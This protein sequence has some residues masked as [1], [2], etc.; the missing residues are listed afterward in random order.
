MQI[1]E[2]CNF[3]GLYLRGK[4]GLSEMVGCLSRRQVSVKYRHYRSIP[5]PLKRSIIEDAF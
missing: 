1:M 3:Q 2:R 4:T 5:S